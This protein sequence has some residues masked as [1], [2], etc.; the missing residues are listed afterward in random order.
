MKSIQIH[1]HTHNK[2]T[3]ADIYI[4]TCSSRCTHMYTQTCTDISM[5]THTPI[6]ATKILVSTCCGPFFVTYKI[7]RG[8]LVCSIMI[9]QCSLL[10]AI[11]Y[12]E[13]SL[14]IHEIKAILPA[15]SATAFSAAEERGC[16]TVH[17]RSLSAL[18][19]SEA[20]S[21]GKRRFSKHWSWSHAQAEKRRYISSSLRESRTSSTSH[22]G[23][24]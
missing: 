2:N 23:T 13:K 18:I 24:H 8:L 14:I 3:C 21:P 6:L 5:N 1:V 7:P 10:I 9:N 17:N 16:L 22:G 19:G 15:A 20:L 12:F 11:S 4:Y